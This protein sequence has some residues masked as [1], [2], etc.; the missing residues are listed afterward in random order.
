MQKQFVENSERIELLEKQVDDLTTYLSKKKGS[1]K[2]DHPDDP[3]SSSAGRYG[4]PF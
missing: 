1:K 4:D 3:G 2:K